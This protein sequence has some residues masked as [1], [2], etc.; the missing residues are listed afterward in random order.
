M[1]IAL[2]PRRRATPRIAAVLIVPFV[3]VILAI[4]L[5][6]SRVEDAAPGAVFGVLDWIQI[7]L[8]AQWFTFETAERLANVALFVP[9][10][11][12]SY[13]ILPR[14]LWPLALLIGGALSAA[15]ELAQAAL[16]QERVATLSDVAANLMGTAVGV[17]LAT[18][19]T[20][21]LAWPRTRA[22]NSAV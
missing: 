16:L 12:L 21:I 3:I 8:G 20:L 15:V 2:A 17:L 22:V 19:C 14:V 1:T 13:L 18:V 5:M 10:G 9:V 6:P 11:I 7:D 4:T